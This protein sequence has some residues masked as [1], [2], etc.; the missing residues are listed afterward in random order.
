MDSVL[1][2][3]YRDID[4]ILVDDGSP[5]GCG[6]ICDEYAAKDP[7]IRVFHIQNSGC[8]GAR[9][10]GIARALERGTEYVILADTDDWLEP[11]MLEKLYS[12]ASA[13]HADIA[14]CGW[15][16]EFQD[17]SFPHPLT[18]G[19]YDKEEAMIRFFSREFTFIIPNKLMRTSLWQ[20]I[21][22]PNGKNYE[23]VYTTYKLFDRAGTVAVIPD[24]AYHYR[25]RSGSIV[26]LDSVRNRV[27]GW[28]AKSQVLAFF[29][30]SAPYN[31]NENCR[32]VLVEYCSNNI[33]EAWTLRGKNA[34][35]ERRQL[36]PEL[37]E[38]AAFV[39]KY[40]K[41][42]DLK[43]RAKRRRWVMLLARR[44]ARPNFALAGIIDKMFGPLRTQHIM[45]D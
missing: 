26:H 10:F 24:P 9:N 28:R 17:A 39:R 22:L 11:D 40:Y 31:Q 4:V 19:V 30:K 44:A 41:Y 34:R 37:K 36:M 38:I 8:A 23:D 3:T 14:I 1:N 27:E 20:G 15:S 16:T 45:F 21:E 29:E 35:E 18:E 12:A 5:D 42:S 7:R 6:R 32:R 2:Q 33:Y 13:H 43:G 25:Q